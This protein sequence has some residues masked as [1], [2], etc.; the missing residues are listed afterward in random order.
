M[1]HTPPVLNGV[2]MSCDNHNDASTAWVHSLEQQLMHINDFSCT[3]ALG[4]VIG[5]NKAPTRTEHYY[6]SRDHTWTPI[7]H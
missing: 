5:W 7:V 4:M 1:V 6:P 3:V 2:H